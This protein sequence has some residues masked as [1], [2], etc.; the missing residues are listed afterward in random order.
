MVLPNIINL[1]TQN[2][3][4]MDMADYREMY[5]TLCAGVSKV[6]DDMPDREPFRKYY[7]RLEALLQEAEDIYI[8]TANVIDLPAESKKK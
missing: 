3:R 7:H 1:A 6:L 4:G 5:Y 8:D 2:I